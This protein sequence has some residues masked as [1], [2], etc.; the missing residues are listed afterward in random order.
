MGGGTGLSRKSKFHTFEVLIV[1]EI[2]IGR[3]SSPEG[4]VRFKKN[5]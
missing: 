4:I 5:Q 3:Y 2:G 1:M